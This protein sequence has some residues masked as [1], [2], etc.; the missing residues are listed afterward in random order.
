MLS[1]EEELSKLTDNARFYIRNLEQQ[2]EA[3]N[4]ETLFLK[5]TIEKLQSLETKIDE[6][7]NQFESQKATLT[8]LADVQREYLKTSTNRIEQIISSSIKFQTLPIVN[9]NNKQLNQNQPIYSGKKEEL[10]AWIN[11]TKTNL[12]ISSIDREDYVKH[13]SVYLRG[14]AQ[15]DFITFKKVN[16]NPTWDEFCENLKRR[17]SSNSYQNRIFEELFNMKCTGP[18]DKHIDKIQFLMNQTENL[19]ELIKIEILVKSLS[20]ESREFLQL[21]NP[22][23]FKEAIDYCVFFADTKSNQPYSTQ[24]VHTKKNSVKK[25]FSQKP[26]ADE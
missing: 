14:I 24:N 1:Q 11:I 2:L 5:S 18:L 16:A 15:Q 6:F 7:I 10:L 9:N 20:G 19:N 22:K 17:F 21:Q 3:E 8:Q 25:K 13:A 12:E 4:N 23:T 26:Q